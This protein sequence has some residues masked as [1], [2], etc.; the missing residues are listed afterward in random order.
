[1]VSVILLTPCYQLANIIIPGGP[2]YEHGS[3]PKLT[4]SW[5]FES[6]ICV[7][8]NIEL[9]RHF[10]YQHMPFQRQIYFLLIL[11]SLFCIHKCVCD[12]VCT[13]QTDLFPRRRV[14]LRCLFHF[15]FKNVNHFRY[16][17]LVFS[18]QIIFVSAVLSTIMHR[19]GHRSHTSNELLI[20]NVGVHVQ[21][22]LSS[23]DPHCVTMSG[24]H[25]T[26]LTS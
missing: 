1:M 25:A 8:N 21:L 15:F 9:F 13:W 10:S 4:F 5:T 20:S 2:H 19:R 3:I 22:Y 26:N 7:E 18:V 23:C 12:L 14:V 24:I 17:T 11:S 16:K 6:T